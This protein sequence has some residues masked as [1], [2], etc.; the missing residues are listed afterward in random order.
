MLC[1]CDDRRNVSHQPQHESYPN[2]NYLLDDI[3][4]GTGYGVLGTPD[5]DCSDKGATV[6][7]VT[8]A[9]QLAGVSTNAI[10][11]FDGLEIWTNGALSTASTRTE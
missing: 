5:A 11:F 7:S 2:T 1:C 3:R 6:S 4:H 9:L 10:R 8:N